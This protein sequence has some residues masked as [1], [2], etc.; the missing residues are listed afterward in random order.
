MNCHGGNA[1]DP[2]W[3]VLASSLRISSWTPLK[4]QPSNPN[5]NPKPLA[6]QLWCIDFLTSPTPLFISACSYFRVGVERLYKVCN[7][8]LKREIRWSLKQTCQFPRMCSPAVT[9]LHKKGPS[10]RR[11]I[12]ANFLWLYSYSSQT[13]PTKNKNILYI[14]EFFQRFNIR[15][16]CWSSSKNLSTSALCRHK[17][18]FG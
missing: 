1:T 18:M 8:R 4:S 5:P 2:I 6:N 11:K 7:F 9:L 15:H 12:C 14:Y 13:S 10:H 3:R 17:K 16:Q